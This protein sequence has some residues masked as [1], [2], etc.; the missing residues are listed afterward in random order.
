MYLIYSSI[1]TKEINE[2]LK[3]IGAKD[4]EELMRQTVP[5]KVL[6]PEPYAHENGEIPDPVSE[7]ILLEKITKLA[8]KNKLYKC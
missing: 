7:K 3:A 2:M 5:E 1:L 6:D 8:E 4:L